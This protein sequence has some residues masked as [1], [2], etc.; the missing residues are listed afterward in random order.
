ME[1]SAGTAPAAADAQPQDAPA[2]DPTQTQ[3]VQPDQQEA[4]SDAQAQLEALQRRVDELTQAQTQG[5]SDLLTAL[6]GE[7]VGLS[8]ED[9]AAYQAGEDPGEMDPASQEAQVA[10]FTD[11][12]KQLIQEENRPLQEERTTEQI[13]AWQKEHPDVVPG[14]PIFDE[15]LA[16]AQ[17]IED[18]YGE[19]AARNVSFLNLAYPAAKAKLADAGAVPAEQAADNGASLETQAGQTQTGDPSD[20]DIYREKVFGTGSGAA[21]GSAF[22]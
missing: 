14:S 22:R 7:D 9:L 4:P 11:W 6:E 10:E 5:P 2:A 12:V 15:I 19:G 18:Q 21:R 17:T 8:P 16:T 13:Q 20:E 3:P 1:A